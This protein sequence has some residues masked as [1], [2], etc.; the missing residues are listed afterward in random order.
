MKISPGP[1]TVY[2][3][4]GITHA[5]APWRFSLAYNDDSGY[6]KNILL[7]HIPH[8]DF[9]PANFT[10]LKEY[11]LTIVIPD[12]DCQK[13]SLGLVNPMT[14]KIPKGS[15]CTYL[16]AGNN[17]MANFTGSCASVYHSCANVQISG[18]TPVADF[19]RN[20][21]YSPPADWPFRGATAEYTQEPSKY[22]NGVMNPRTYPQVGECA[23][24][25]E[26]LRSRPQAEA[27]AA[28][29]SFRTNYLKPPFQT[30]IAGTAL[31]NLKFLRNNVFIDIS[32]SETWEDWCLTVFFTTAPPAD[33][34]AQLP[35]Q[36]NGIRVFYDVTGPLLLD[37][38]CP[39]D[40][41]PCEDGS[42]A[43]RG[44]EECDFQCPAPTDSSFPVWG[45]ILAASLAS[46]VIVGLAI[47]GYKKRTKKVLDL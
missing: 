45:I 46:I 23:A 4:E 12:V 34:R 3:E 6:E 10:I 26:K 44:G 43:T 11:M 19:F 33:V 37:Q 20:Y 27:T 17:S 41:I 1:F 22:Y 39:P 18:K 32:A 2:W 38:F 7:D 35:N 42:V 29:T 13:C 28:E 9:G 30:Y 8:N 24:Q 15:R 31:S 47:F 21:R 36:I 14:D 40:Q 25:Y 16:F 5:G